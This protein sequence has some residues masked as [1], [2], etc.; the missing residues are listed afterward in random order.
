MEHFPK[1]T[2]RNGISYTLIR[3]YYITDLLLLGEKIFIGI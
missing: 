2:C 1:K 3:D